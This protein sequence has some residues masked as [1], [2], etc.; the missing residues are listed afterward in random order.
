M[1]PNFYQ[2]ESKYAIC[3]ESY[4]YAW[5]VIIDNDSSHEQMVKYVNVNLDPTN[6]DDYWYG[7][8]SVEIFQVNTMCVRHKGEK[9]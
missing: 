8:C 3:A 1:L 7:Q 9:Y 2:P 6:V 4:N 5:I